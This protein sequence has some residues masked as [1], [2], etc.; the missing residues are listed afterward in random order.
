MLG[1]LLRA[2]VKTVI[3]PISVVADVVTGLDDSIDGRVG[4][5]TAGHIRSIADDLDDIL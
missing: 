2:A 1:S 5:R 4:H 3:L